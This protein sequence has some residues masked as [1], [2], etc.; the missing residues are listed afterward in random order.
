[1]VKPHATGG[2]TNADLAALFDVIRST[3]YRAIQRDAAR[4]R[5]RRA[6]AREQSRLVDE[7]KERGYIIVACGVLPD[8]L[9]TA[10]K[11]MRTLVLRGQ[12]RI[13]FH[14][15]SPARRRQILAAI[16]ATSASASVYI[17]DTYR[18]EILARAACLEAVVTDAAASGAHMLVLE[19][20]D[21]LLRWDRKLLYELTRKT[22]CADTLRY[23]HHRGSNEE[24]LWIPD[25]IA[26]CWARGGTWRKLVTPIIDDVRTV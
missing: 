19:Q 1:L 23:E 5:G 20:D 10:R 7:S 18:R 14:T 26:W 11:A 24:L 21:S 17:G 6:A 13:H 25:A 22:G 4:T 12:T 9:A 15:E 8:R 3:V 2:Y 16:T